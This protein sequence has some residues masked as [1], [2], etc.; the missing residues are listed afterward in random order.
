M[1]WREWNGMKARY[2]QVTTWDAML[3]VCRHYGRSGRHYCNVNDLSVIHGEG[4]GAC[5]VHCGL[6]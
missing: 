4:M 6:D 5:V 1:G 2:G 3:R